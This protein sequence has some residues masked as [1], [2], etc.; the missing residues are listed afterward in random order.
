MVFGIVSKNGT[1]LG[2]NAMVLVIGVCSI[3]DS[4]NIICYFLF[5]QRKK[6]LRN[7]SFFFMKYRNFV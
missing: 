1:K 4:A 2:K 7:I 5:V 3:A 6:L